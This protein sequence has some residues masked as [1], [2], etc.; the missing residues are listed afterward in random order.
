MNI[1]LIRQTDT[2]LTNYFP[3]QPGQA[4]IKTVKP[5]GILMKQEMTGGSGISWTICKSFVAPRSRQITRPASHH[6]IFYRPD[7]LPHAQLTVS[8][9][10]STDQN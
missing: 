1:S 8:K 7:A 6:S 10:R 4:S 9:Q 2:C 3:G 5:I